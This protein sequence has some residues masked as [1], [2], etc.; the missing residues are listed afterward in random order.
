MCGKT[1]CTKSSSKAC[2]C[3]QASYHRSR[4]NPMHH[5]LTQI[6]VCINR[7]K[8]SVTWD[9]EFGAT[10]YPPHLFVCAVLDNKT[11]CW[12]PS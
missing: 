7:P 12:I 5:V 9:V 4:F 11:F 10:T 3:S 8:R 1:A 6:R 2:R